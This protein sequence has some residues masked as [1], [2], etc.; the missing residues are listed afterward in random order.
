M[1]ARRRGLRAVSFASLERKIP[2]H[3]MIS[4]CGYERKVCGDQYVWD[5]ARRGSTEFF[6]WQL[7]LSGRGMLAYEGKNHPQ[8]PGTAMFL[9]IPH[10]HCYF[11][12][13]D[14]ESW[15]FIYLCLHGHEVVRLLKHLHAVA[16][17]RMVF[18]GSSP[19]VELALDICSSAAA[20]LLDEAFAN[21]AMAYRFAMA[22]LSESMPGSRVCDKPRFVVEVERF[23][24][25][26]LSEN[27][28]VDEMAGAAGLSRYHFSRLFKSFRGESPGV[29]L[30]NMR[31]RFAAELLGSSMLAI[32]DVG[33]RC[34]FRDTSYFCMIFRKTYGLTP[35]VFRKSGMYRAGETGS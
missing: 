17:C 2:L 26:H 33:E 18:D 3:S 15:E 10:E 25:E 9:R 31:L 11:L 5:G 7:T 6:L 32:N 22:L 35:E 23:C 24:R 28:G 19:V 29:F 16:G 12:P 20:G 4:S 27:I 21:S 34:G 30:R 1:K 8:E 13:D 14:S